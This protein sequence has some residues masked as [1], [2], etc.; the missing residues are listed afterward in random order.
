MS[1]HILDDAE[2]GN[3]HFFEHHETLT[4]V[5]QSD[6]LR[7]RYH[8][9]ACQRNFLRQRELNVAGSRGHINDE[10]VQVFPIGL[11]Q[12]LLECGNCQRTSPNHR[13]IR[14]DEHADGS[15]L[16]TVSNHRFKS[17]T[18]NGVRFISDAE[19]SR[20]ARTVNV[21][22]QQADFG[23]FLLKGKC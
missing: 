22:I 7:S 16:Q 19:H 12:K 4:S 9:G 3:V 14:I 17:L 1:S 6:V 20:L 21:G 8:Y 2:D 23:A 5:H 10:V 13:L 11:F 18:V 15:D